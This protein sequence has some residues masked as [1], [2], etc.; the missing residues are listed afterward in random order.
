LFIFFKYYSFYQRESD[1]GQG[2]C[3]EVCGNCSDP[4]QLSNDF[5]KNTNGSTWKKS[6]CDPKLNRQFS[7]PTSLY[8][9]QFVGKFLIF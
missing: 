3:V 9:D 4:I 6:I 7:N 8:R 5:D 2:C 1:I